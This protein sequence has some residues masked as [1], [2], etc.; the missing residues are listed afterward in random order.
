LP[1]L[2]ADPPKIYL[3]AP[4]AAIAYVDNHT[5]AIVDTQGQL[6]LR[7]KEKTSGPLASGLGT[8]SLMNGSDR[9]E[10]ALVLSDGTVKIVGAGNSRPV[11]VLNGKA[12]QKLK[13]I[14]FTPD[15]HLVGLGDKGARFVWSINNDSPMHEEPL[16]SEIN[17]LLGMSGDGNYFIAR[18]SEGRLALWDATSRSILTIYDHSQVTPRLVAIS[19]TR[20]YVAAA[21]AQAPDNLL[22]WNMGSGTFLKSINAPGEEKIALLF[23]EGDSRLVTLDSAGKLRAFDCATGEQLYEES[24]GVVRHRVTLAVYREDVAHVAADGNVAISPPAAA[25][26]HPKYSLAPDNVLEKDNKYVSVPVFFGTNRG[27]RSKTSIWKEFKGFFATTIGYGCL[28]IAAVLILIAGLWKGTKPA[29]AILAGSLIIIPLLALLDASDRVHQESSAP[30]G[31]FTDECD[32]LR[33]GRCE[34]TIPR[35]HSIGQ[36]ESP[37]QFWIFRGD[38]DPNAHIILQK[39]EVFPGN[40]S[41][42]Q[43]LRDTFDKDGNGY[44]ALVFVHGYNVSFN[45]ATRRTAQLAYDLE[46]PGAPICYSWPSHSEAAQYPKDL[47]NARESVPEFRRFLATV[48]QKTGAKKI[49]IVAHSMGTMLV[50]ESLQRPITDDDAKQFR[51]IVLAAP[52]IDQKVFLDQIA[53]AM[54]SGQRHLT[55]YASSNDEAL[56]MSMKFNGEQRAGATR[57]KVTLL[58]GMD[59]IDASAVD[60]SFMGHSYFAS[61]A[62]LI[63]DLKYLLEHDKPVD[64]RFGLSKQSID[65]GDYWAFT[66]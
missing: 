13:A 56:A 61:A 4:A 26:E 59:T 27:D 43:A 21:D 41:F 60:T 6:F 63:N 22:L 30:G 32:S 66:Q 7:D 46:F 9:G 24:V 19:P 3:R 38:A 28:V 40:E 29:R 36:L 20:K 12:T 34:I 49:H 10:L 55:L 5:L 57:P 15:R 48:A 47:T 2:G 33:L 51:Q 18:T 23:G 42:V 64:Q 45:E 52:D 16:G 17:E 37:P 11:K 1:A 35:S 62:Q 58:K 65:D 31:T 39:A 25:A 14:T 54:M 53:P 8:V 44:D 50:G